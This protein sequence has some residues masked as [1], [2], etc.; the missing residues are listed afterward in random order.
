[1][2]NPEF[3]LAAAIAGSALL[4]VEVASAADLAPRSYKNVLP[5]VAAA[6]YDWSGF[7]VGA[8]GGWGS[9]RK[10]WDVNSLLP[11]FPG[12]PFV[13]AAEGCHDAT[14]GTAG[15]QIGYR[16]Q[17]GAFVIGLEAQGNWADLSGSNASA[18]LGGVTNR[19]KIDAFGLFTGQAGYAWKNALLYI[20]GG[21]AV[22]RDAYAGYNTA[23]GNGLDNAAETRVGGVAG[24]GLEYGFTP[25]WTAA[26]EYDHLFMGDRVVALMSPAGVFS[27]EDR[28]HQDVDLITVRLNYKFGSPVV[29]RY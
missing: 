25:N 4:S 28:I 13:A 23:T 7:Y 22:T 16:L 17:T 10:C 8:N 20:K 2:R 9:S 11:V 6:T 14:G 12:G 27:R 21:T 24:L 3:V 29:A 26:L 5:I 15:G 18:F 19:S 1:M